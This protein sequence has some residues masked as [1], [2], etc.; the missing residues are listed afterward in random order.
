MLGATRAEPLFGFLTSA[1]QK[2]LL[3]DLSS[4]LPQ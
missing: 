4:S 1:L 3:I 2:R